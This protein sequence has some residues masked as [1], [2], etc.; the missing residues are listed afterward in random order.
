MIGET[1]VDGVQT[2]LA[3]KS[4]PVAAGLAFRVGRADETLATAGITHLLEHLALHGVGLG[5]YHHNGATGSVVTHFHLRGSEDDVVK[6]LMAVCDALADLPLDRLETE[7]DILRTEAA[8]RKTGANESMPLWRYG[9]QGHGLVSFEEFGLPRLTAD[10]VREWA[11]TWF[12]R[13]NAVLW[14][15]ADQVPAGLRLNLPEGTRRPVPQPSSALPTTPAYFTAHFNAVVF[16]AVVRRRT[17]GSVFSAVLERELYRSLRQEGGYSYTAN[18]SYD[19]R[20]AGFAVVT[21]FADAVP[22]KQDAV[23]G[24]FVDVLAKLQVGRFEQADL[25]SVRTQAEEALRHDG[26]DAARLPAAAVNALVGHPH[27]TAAELLDEVRAVTVDD[28]HEVAMETAGSGLLLVPRGHD[29]EWAGYALAPAFSDTVVD[30]LRYQPRAGGAARLVVGAEGVSVV[31][32]DHALTVRY[33]ECA[34]AMA[35]PDGGR[36]LIGL[37]GI[38]VRVEPTVFPV[39]ADQL[40]RI[41]ASVPPGNLM[42]LPAREPTAIPRPRPRTPAAP[43]R[44]SKAGLIVLIVLASIVGLIAVLDAAVILLADPVNNPEN[45]ALREPGSF[46]VL[47]FLLLVT[48]SFVIWAVHVARMRK[49][50]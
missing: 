15:T 42:R 12:T 50:T 8:T 32:G 39:K 4:G 45:A 47:G 43:S 19:P 24:G 29:A 9:A 31:D 7:K 11:A 20:D 17:A 13:Q 2:L 22:D 10:E 49:I 16:D 1:E 5:D 37:D 23:L 40:A 36:Q 14:V 35:W 27:Q 34:L 6:H 46:T 48:A 25:D 21:A 44:A 38:S 28:L 41:D 26:S 18:A 33:A 3:P 30:G